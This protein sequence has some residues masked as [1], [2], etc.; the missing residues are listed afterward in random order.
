VWLGNGK[1]AAQVY[2]VNGTTNVI[3][4]S[5]NLSL[6]TPVLTNNVGVYQFIDVTAGNYPFR[7]YRAR[8]VP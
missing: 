6:W 8:L 1:F 2:A 3:E 5:T 7:F 4:A